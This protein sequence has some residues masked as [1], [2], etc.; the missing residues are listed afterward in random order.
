M[1]LTSW[2]EYLQNLLSKVRSTDPHFLDDLPTLPIIQ[3]LDDPLSFDEVEKAILIDNNAAYPDNILPGVIKYGG[4]SLHQ[5][6]LN[7]IRDCWSAKCLQQQWKNAN[8]ILPY[9]QKGDRAECG[10]SQSIS[11]LSVASKVLAK[12]MLTHLLEHVDLVLPECQFGFWC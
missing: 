9:K 12:L 2:T 4:C 5:T 3:N 1:I 11:L 7:L 10:S 6:L 8:I